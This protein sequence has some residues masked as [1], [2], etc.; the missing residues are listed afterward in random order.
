VDYVM[1]AVALRRGART[2][3]EKAAEAEAADGAVQ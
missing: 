3:A 2:G 1:R